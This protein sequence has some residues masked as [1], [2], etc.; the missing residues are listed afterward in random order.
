MFL[1]FSSS[2]RALNGFAA[3]QCRACRT[4]RSLSTFAISAILLSGPV[5]RSLST[6]FHGFLAAHK[7]PRTGPSGRGHSAPQLGS[8][9]CGDRRPGCDR[10]LVVRHD[11]ESRLTRLQCFPET[12]D[13][14]PNSFVNESTAVFGRKVDRSLLASWIDSR[15]LREATEAVDGA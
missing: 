8:G 7:P 15:P 5:R 4:H 11:F 9:S 14:I 13:D 1:L 3:K 2:H 6:R 12:V 10:L